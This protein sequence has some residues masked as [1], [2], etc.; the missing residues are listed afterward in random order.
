MTRI[1]HPKY[2]IVGEPAAGTFTLGQFLDDN[3]DMDV[4]EIE[5]IRNLRKG[6]SVTLGGG[7]GGEYTIKR[8]V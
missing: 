5:A 1:P 6:S 8:V 2:R 7:A 3:L 4:Q